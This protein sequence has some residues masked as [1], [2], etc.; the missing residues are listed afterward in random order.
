MERIKGFTLAELMGVI[1][2]LGIL[3]IIVVPV[4][5]KNIKKGV[6]VTCKT[7][8]HS[9]IEAAKNYHSDSAGN[10]GVDSDCET[11][12]G[13]CQVSI[14][15]LVSSGYLKGSNENNTEVSPINP[16]TNEPYDE[17]S[18]VQI[19]NTT[20]ANYVYTVIYNGNDK[21]ACKEW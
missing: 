19:N 18:F 12:G 6:K 16:A 4:V 14:R 7:Q 13:I 21:G 10:I 5:D 2:I 3:A 1:V 8:E 11:K 20:G 15:E 9:I 17:G